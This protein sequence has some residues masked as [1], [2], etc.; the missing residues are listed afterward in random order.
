MLDL[1]GVFNVVK[2]RYISINKE[3]TLNSNMVCTVLEEVALT[4]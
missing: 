1:E 2:N 4:L 3:N